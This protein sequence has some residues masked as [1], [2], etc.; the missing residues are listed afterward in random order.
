MIGWRIPLWL[1]RISCFNGNS[2]FTAGNVKP[3]AKMGMTLRAAAFLCR[4]RLNRTGLLPMFTSLATQIE[5][6]VVAR[7]SERYI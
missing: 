6:I 7:S 2:A 1:T 3:T 4:T 5:L